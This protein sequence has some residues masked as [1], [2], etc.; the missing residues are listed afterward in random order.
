[1]KTYTK[2]E[3]NEAIRKSTDHVEDSDEEFSFEYI[4]IGDFKFSLFGVRE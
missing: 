4:D 3:I 1:M 2:E